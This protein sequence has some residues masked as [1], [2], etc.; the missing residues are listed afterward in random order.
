MAMALT[1]R[2]AC[3]PQAAPGELDAAT[4]AA[5]RRGEP[6]ALRRFVVRYERVVFAF[7]SRTLGAGPHV[8]DLAQE[9][10][11]RAI[12]ALPRFEPRPSARLST[13][14]LK[15]AVRLAQ[16]ER[17]RRPPRFEPLGEH[18]GAEER[19]P[20]HEHEA[21]ELVR[22]LERA[23]ASLPTEQRV[24]LVLAQFHGLGL[25]EIGELVDAPVATVKTRLF[26]ARERMRALL[27]SEA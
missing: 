13:W 27:G 4:L 11:L 6:L 8:E 2:I 21:R 25:E 3:E 23:A 16:D 17:R 1:A 19:T 14:L 24:V 12:R 22:V 5:A 7:L 15:I 18:D 9:V 26:R 10:F 20:E